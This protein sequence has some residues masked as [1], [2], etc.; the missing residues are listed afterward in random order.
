MMVPPRVLEILRCVAQYGVLTAAQIRSLCFPTIQSD[1]SNVRSRMRDMVQRKLVN[2][3]R[4]QV[5]NP[6]ATLAAPVYYSAPLGLEV[7]ACQLN[8]DRYRLVSTRAPH[9]QNLPHAVA[10]ADLH[11]VADQAVAQQSYVKL[12]RW[13]NEFDIVN[14]AAAS[15]SEI[16]RAHV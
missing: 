2:R 1:G 16:G 6:M 11:I 9:W 3:T 7:L 5:V 12:E 8:D 15:P 13:V 10:I 14:T 4:M